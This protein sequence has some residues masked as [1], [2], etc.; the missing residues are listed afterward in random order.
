M[1]LGASSTNDG[2]REFYAP[3][4]TETPK[5]SQQRSMPQVEHQTSQRP[6]ELHRLHG[7]ANRTKPDSDDQTEAGFSREIRNY[8]AGDEFVLLWKWVDDFMDK[9]RA[10]NNSSKSHN[11]KKPTSRQPK[12]SPSSSQEARRIPRPAVTP[13]PEAVRRQATDREDMR[14]YMAQ[15]HTPWGELFYLYQNWKD[16]QAKKKAD[17]ARQVR[18]EQMSKSQATE[19][20]DEPTRGRSETRRKPPGTTP[21]PRD[22]DHAVDSQSGIGRKPVPVHDK[23]RGEVQKHAVKITQLPAIHKS[24]HLQHTPSNNYRAKHSP[25]RGQKDKSNRDTRFSDFLHQQR[26]APPSQKPAPSRETQW[27]YAVPGEDDELVRNSRFSSIL[28]PAKAIKKAKEVEKAKGPVCYICGS[29]NCPGG[30]R[31]NITNL[32]VCA[33]CQRAEKIGPAQCSVCGE[34]NSPGTGYASNGLWM[35]TACSNP[36]T[37]KELP[38]TPK[39]SRKDTSRM[40]KVSGP[41]IP[42]GVEKVKRE[43]TEQCECDHPCRPIEIFDKMI[44]ICPDCHKRLTPFP[45]IRS[46]LALSLNRRDSHASLASQGVPIS[47]YNS[48]H[49]YSDDAYETRATTPPSQKPIGLGI[50]IQDSEEEVEEEECRPTPPVKDSKFY[51]D[52]AA[53]PA[54]DYNQS[55]L[56]KP[57]TKHPYA[58]S[59]AP[60]PRK[61]SVSFAQDL[62]SAKASS[63]RSK[64]QRHQQNQSFNPTTYPYPSPPSSPTSL[65]K[66]R[67][68]SSV[69]P[70]DEPTLDF[71]YPPPPIPQEFVTR[72][73]RSSSV[74]PGMLSKAALARTELVGP[75]SQ[76]SPVSTEGGRRVLNRRSSWYDFWKPVFEKTG[77]KSP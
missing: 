36:T 59:P 34:P 60:T 12:P 63:T 39:L 29:F 57:G 47:E 64:K 43:S 3:R 62:P 74:T 24:I 48:D 68:A 70:T 25:N 10:K 37:P 14:E 55:Y 15:R 26:N 31:D 27:T 5:R 61:A 69:Y 67:P 45:V 71:P 9:R 58:P 11:V 75:R 53:L 7:S 21:S 76:S 33:V 54:M 28:D 16:Q 30:Y 13:S 65:H 52:S 38:P 18:R 6:I 51:R 44:S 72:P 19:H 20:K 41:P 2:F 49:L 56:R 42:Q 66:P 17:Q 35:C 46:K 22:Q 4:T 40:S 1:A 50:T 73:K 23:K 8:K 32:W 77:E